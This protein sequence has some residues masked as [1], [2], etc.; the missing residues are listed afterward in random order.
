MAFRFDFWPYE[1]KLAHF[2][3]TIFGSTQL[4]PY[5]I[6]AIL[7][8]CHA[9]I[10]QYSIF[11][12]LKFRHTQFSPYSNFAILNFRHTQPSP[13]SI[14]AMHKFCQRNLIVLYMND[15]ITLEFYYICYL[16]NTHYG[17]SSSSPPSLFF[18]IFPHSSVRK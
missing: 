10:S 15:W 18:P 8:F 17:I 12:I 7:K 1:L 9:Q 14:F 4:S 3:T 2:Y 16:C 13:Y 6:F 11:A 5:S